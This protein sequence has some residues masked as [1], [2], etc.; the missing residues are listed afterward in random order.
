MNIKRKESDIMPKNP[1][2]RHEYKSNKK[3]P[4][5]LYVKHSLTSPY[6]LVG[7]FD[8]SI[9]AHKYLDE[10][11]K[12]FP[13][14]IMKLSA[15]IAE[16]KKQEQ[17]KEMVKSVGK[18]IVSGAEAIGRGAAAV[19]R[20]AEIASER[21]GAAEEKY[22][23]Y[24]SDRDTKAMEREKKELE[25]LRRENERMHLMLEKRELRE[26][27]KLQAEQDRLLLQEKAL[28]LEQKRQPSYQRPFSSNVWQPPRTSS[29][30][31]P[32]NIW[33]PKKRKKE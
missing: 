7:Q 6:E 26:Q 17:R 14:K 1:Y 16:G 10:H 3:E 13:F 27:Q 18:K 15:A 22:R 28:Q 23:K 8:T 33:A 12:N 2:K 21:L 29:T 5:L 30:F 4:S 9:D 31:N 20:G 24:W 32:P 25:K 11:Y 19:G